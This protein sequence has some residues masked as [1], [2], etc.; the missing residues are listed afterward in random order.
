MRRTAADE[1]AFSLHYEATHNRRRI[2]PLVVACIV[3]AIIAGLTMGILWKE[4]TQQ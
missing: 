4:M 1:E 3:G 2:P